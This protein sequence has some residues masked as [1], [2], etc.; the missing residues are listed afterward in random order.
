M[1]IIPAS[2]ASLQA[3]MPTKGRNAYLHATVSYFT[4]SAFSE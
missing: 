1:R 4:I 3:L 2:P